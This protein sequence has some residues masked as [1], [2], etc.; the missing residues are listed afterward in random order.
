MNT[1]QFIGEEAGSEI[2]CTLCYGA[3]LWMEWGRG[4][5]LKIWVESSYVKTS[6]TQSDYHDPI[7]N[8]PQLVSIPMSAHSIQRS[9]WFASNVLVDS[10]E[11]KCWRHVSYR[12]CVCVVHLDR[13]SVTTS[14]TFFFYNYFSEHKC[15][16]VLALGLEPPQHLMEAQ[17]LDQMALQFRIVAG[18]D[19][20]LYILDSWLSWIG[21][22][23]IINSKCL[24]GHNWGPVLGPIPKS[25]AKYYKY[26]AMDFGDYVHVVLL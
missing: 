10:H 3:N 23:P 5:D 20:D 7:I 14:T 19:F 9:N 13:S 16:Y 25:M 18:V 21:W 1:Y 17:G 6:Q 12:G 26:L 22:F 11:C 15:T 2:L 4:K 24:H 8:C